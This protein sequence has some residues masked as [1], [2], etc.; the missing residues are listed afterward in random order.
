MSEVKKKGISSFLFLFFNKFDVMSFLNIDKIVVYIHILMLIILEAFYMYKR[1]HIKKVKQLLYY[2]TTM[3][4][5]T[6]RIRQ[7]SLLSY[8][9]LSVQIVLL[10]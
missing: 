3:I 8:L 10:I 5:N 6:L 4:I 1:L 2:D 7:Q 9:L